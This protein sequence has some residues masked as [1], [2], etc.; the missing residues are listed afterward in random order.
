MVSLL[1]DLPIYY[2][3]EEFKIKTKWEVDVQAK[4]EVPQI[5]IIAYI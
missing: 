5:H 4:V 2:T 1:Y 3:N